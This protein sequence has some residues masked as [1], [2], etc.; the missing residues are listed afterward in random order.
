MI[1]IVK[2]FHFLE[3]TMKKSLFVLSLAALLTFVACEKKKEE[4]KEGGVTVE[5]AKEAT[6]IDIPKG[7]IYCSSYI[8]CIQTILPFTRKNN[9]IINIDH[10]LDEFECIADKKYFIGDT[11]EK[12][13]NLLSQYKEHINKKNTILKEKEKLLFNNSYDTLNTKS[14]DIMNFL[15]YLWKQNKNNQKYILCS[16][17]TTLAI[18]KKIITFNTNSISI[19]ENSI[20]MGKI[21]KCL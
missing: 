9:L 18:L 3:D 15:I 14:L 7:N 10:S 6:K 19:I 2:T 12:R 8:R 17:Q 4:K 16:H 20:E 21:I 1:L 5:A 13:N 11:I